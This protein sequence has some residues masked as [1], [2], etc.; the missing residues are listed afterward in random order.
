MFDQI[1]VHIDVP[2][3]Y[4]MHISQYMR[5]VLIMLCLSLCVHMYTNVF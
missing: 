3:L 2:E 4:L 1:C 5:Y